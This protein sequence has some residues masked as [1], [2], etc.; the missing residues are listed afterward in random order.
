MVRTP[1]TASL[2]RA[3]S[4][5]FLFVCVAALP[6]MAA[7]VTITP[8][9]WK[10]YVNTRY[11]VIV[12]YPADLFTAE[13]APPDNAGRGFEAAAFKARFSIYSH[14]NA[15]DQSRDA[16]VAADVQELAAKT[17][18]QMRGADW[19]QI[20]GQKNGETVLLRVLLRDDDRMLHRLLIAYPAAMTDAFAPIV[21]RMTKS[22]RVDAK[23]PRGAAADAG[24][25]PRWDG[26][27]KRID[28]IALGLRIPGFRGKVGLSA[29]V[30]AD[31]VRADLPEPNSI[32]FDEPQP[33]G[34]RDFYAIFSAEARRPRASLAGEAK[35]VKDRAVELADRYRLL[36]ERRTAIATRPAVVLEMEYAASDSNAM[37]FESIAV[38]DAGQVFYFLHFGSPRARMAEARK[39]FDRIVAT[40]AFAE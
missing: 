35:L 11:G 25:A 33:S 30:P 4:W 27:L 31:W 26:A 8:S 16:L 24:R 21:A 3:A 17:V 6:A 37:L 2:W 40:I 9:V 15:L 38:I 7:T 18:S 39:L 14:A 10:I 22:F 1:Q 36:S 20:V 29:E 19:Y 23:I 13:P 32:E 12:D 5:L 28:T 34:N